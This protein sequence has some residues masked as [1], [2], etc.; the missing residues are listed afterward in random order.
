MA[1]WIVVTA[2]SA[3]VVTA[4]TEPVEHSPSAQRDRIGGTALGLEAPCLVDV[5][6]DISLQGVFNDCI[7][8]IHLRTDDCTAED[9]ELQFIHDDAM[10]SVPARFTG[11]VALP[12]GDWTFLCV[13]DEQHTLSE[14]TQLNIDG[15][16]FV[17]KPVTLRGGDTN[18]DDKVEVQDISFLLNMFGDLQLES[19]C[20][21][22]ETQDADFSCNG[23]VGMVDFVILSDNYFNGSE[24]QCA[25]GQP[26][27]L[28]PPPPGGRVELIDV[29]LNLD[30]PRVEVGQLVEI[31]IVVRSSGPASQPFVT[32]ESLFDWDPSALRLLG[33]DD[34]GAGAEWLLSD[35]LPEQDDVND[36]IDD[37]C[38]LHSAVAAL[39]S[40]ET[41]PSTPEG[42]IV[43]TL[44]FVALTEINATEVRLV[45]EIGL[46][47]R[48]R[49]IASGP[50]F[51]TGDISSTA[52]LTILPG[53]PADLDGNG[54]VGIDDFD[55]LLDQWG[56]DP[57]GPPD[58]DFD[59]NVGIV[60]FLLLLSLWGPCS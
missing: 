52:T 24:C 15:T 14:T 60:D 40:S 46:F 27:V 51:V 57:G 23:V 41:A 12:C 1:A 47:A 58:F 37:G 32:I 7:R 36:D 9:F 16:H 38:A 21:W 39:G 35:F 5:E 3:G 43:T 8:C 11:T 10:P 44:R 54:A 18:N 19:R 2:A 4:P 53:C 34:S 29:I 26:Q 33:I 17:A 50:T 30:S 56:T 28:D 31:D 42:L 13:K 49:V 59:G 45:D 22:N 6:L 25:S 20:P 48:T 55:S